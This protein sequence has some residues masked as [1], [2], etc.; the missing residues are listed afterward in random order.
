MSDLSLGLVAQLLGRPLH[1]ADRPVDSVSSDSRDLQPGALFVAL[2]GPHFD[3][4]RFL[5]AARQAGAVGALVDEPPQI[6]LPWIQVD[7]TRRAL[8]RL[9]AGWRARHPLPLVAVTG[10]NGKTTVKE[11]VA[12]ILAQQGAVLATRGNLNNDIGLPLTLLRLRNEAFAVLEM[13]A[14]HPGEITYL[15]RIARPDL[16]IITNAGAAHLEGFGDLQGV[17]RAKGEILAALADQGV[18]VLNADDPHYAL[19]R[20]LAGRR[21]VVSFGL[22]APAEV[23]ADPARLETRW[24]PQGFYMEC[25]VQTPA[26]GLKIRL[27]LAGQHNLANALAAIAGALALQLSPSAIGAGL[28]SVRPVAGR[29]ACRLSP[30]GVRLIDDSYNANP[31]S[32]AA[33]IQVLRSAPG[34]R[35]L[36]L[37]ELAELGPQAQALHARVGEQAR[38]AGIDHLWAVGPLSQAAVAAFGPGGRHFTDRQALIR[39]LQG[40]LQAG[41]SLL[42]KGS[43]SAAMEQVVWELLGDPAPS[44]RALQGGGR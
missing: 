19:W 33:A 30:T 44:T 35:W 43:R 6:D 28:A 37:G 31:D 42:I 1:G 29:L 34:R 41:D 16:A 17:A 7:D 36:A 2:R 18:A 3:G 13:G 39:A 25:P 21:R 26:G 32:V 20:E 4:H 23:T 38:A 22:H 10:S 40:A 8:G 11:M 15:G 14:N 5:D 27:A 9:A 24:T 12:A